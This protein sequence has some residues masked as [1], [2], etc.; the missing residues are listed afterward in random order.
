VSY[1]THRRDALDRVQPL[2]HRRSHARSLA[3]LMGQKYRV[4][5]AHVFDLVRRA[6]GVDLTTAVEDTELIAA[7]RV[8]DRIKAE[9]LGA[10]IAPDAESNAASDNGA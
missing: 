5:R 6:C 1:S 7:V 8:L 4:P 3:M 10:A 9:G 2:P